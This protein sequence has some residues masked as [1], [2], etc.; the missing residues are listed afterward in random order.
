M[1]PFEVVAMIIAAFFGL[2]VA[3]GIFLVMALPGL[4]QH[5]YVKRH[6]EGGAG[7]LPSAPPGPP[8]PYDEPDRPPPW[9][10]P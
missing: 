7:W 2:G 10:G 8:A 5:R 6:P 1:N 4:R 3:T 9:P